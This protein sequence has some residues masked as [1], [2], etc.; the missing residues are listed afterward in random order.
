M[1]FKLTTEQEM[2]KNMVREFTEKE[3]AP[4]DGEMDKKGEFPWH[5]ID[6]MREN[7]IFGIPFPEEYGGAGADAICEAITL[8]ELGRGSASVAITLDA[9]MLC[10]NPMHLF[11][12]EEQKKKY[13]PDLVSGKKLGAFG[14]TEPCAG[15]DAAGIQTMAK[16]EE[17]HY[18]LNGRKAWITNFSV[19]DVYIIAAKTNPDAGVKGIS[20]FIV[21][22]GTPGFIIGDKEDKMG[23]RGSDTGELIF[24]NCK[25]PKENLLGSEGQ[26]FKIA[27]IALDSG[28]M[29]VG[30]FGVGIA[31]HAMEEAIKYANQ[32]TAFGKNIGKFQAIQF[33]IADMAT[34]IAAARNLVYAAA[35]KRDCKERFSLEAAMAKL[36]SAEAAMKITKN[37]IQVFGGYGYSRE[38]PV[39]RLLRDAKILEIG[40][41]TSE[42]L[43]MVIGGSM[44]K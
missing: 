20:A 25:I 37:A 41:G 14:L 30:A 42:I 5:I 32:R 16:L 39:E 28:R 15:S 12:T 13:L 22:K 18:V 26:G 40:E 11:G 24:D 27:M 21:E 9:H 2:I 34:E 1:N 44:V 43:R 17:D 6:K 4:Y 19:A 8:E 36:Y 10:A 31:Q 7:D 29:G 38:Y 35:F 3:V 33:M 23:V